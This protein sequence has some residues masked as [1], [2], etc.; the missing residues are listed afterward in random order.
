[1][2]RKTDKWGDVFYQIVI[3][4]PVKSKSTANQKQ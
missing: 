2:D 1:M 4:K 3:Y